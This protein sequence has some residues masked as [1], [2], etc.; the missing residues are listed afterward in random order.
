MCVKSGRREGISSKLPNMTGW[1][2]QDIFK[3]VVTM[4]LMGAFI[5]MFLPFYAE[6]LLAAVFALAIEPALGRILQS[7]QMRWKA[8][9]AGILCLMFLFV[10]GPISMVAYKFYIYVSG[11]SQTGFQNTELFKKLVFFRGQLL[12]LAN[13]MLQTLRLEDQIDL[14]GLSEEALNKIGNF[15]VSA[16][17]NAVYHVPSILLSVFVFCVALY[18][19][20]AEARLIKTGFLNM[21]FLTPKESEK[22]VE[23]MQRASYSTVV[24]SIS[25]GL[26]AATIVALG[27]WA[28]NAGDFSVVFVI[29][30]FCSFIPVIG[31]GPVA[32]VLALYK[33]VVGSYGEAFGLVAV[34]AFVG[35][36]DNLVRPYLISSNDEEMHPAV[37][38]LALMGALIVFGM[39]GV[40]LGPVIASIAI[41]V[42]E[43]FYPNPEA[44]TSKS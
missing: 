16:S 18:F 44:A 3:L 39:P 25:L 31:A 17:T 29:T 20:L 22:L 37:S 33:F 41:R 34:A 27:G 35:V 11:V 30:F 6:T 26:M 38:L 10:A 12:R 14:A 40:F 9:V 24:T 32:F 23:V 1:R 36:V 19:F 7:K 4:V 42:T 8:S 15:A 2:K 21:K 5:A 43:I 28:L 13:Q